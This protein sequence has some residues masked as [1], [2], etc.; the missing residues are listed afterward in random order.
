MSGCC[1]GSSAMWACVDSMPDP[2]LCRVSQG[3]A[4]LERMLVKAQSKKAKWES[5]KQA[6]KPQIE[7]QEA[8]L[9]D[10]KGALTGLASPRLAGLRITDVAPV[11]GV[12][13]S[14]PLLAYGERLLAGRT[15]Q[16][17]RAPHA[18]QPSRLGKPTVS[19]PPPVPVRLPPIC[20]QA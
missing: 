13:S 9:A 14:K 20:S 16:A 3:V 17:K 6:L 7:A 1:P 4:E 19:D 5:E 11:C 10:L 8:V 12:E 18:A 15:A 2:R